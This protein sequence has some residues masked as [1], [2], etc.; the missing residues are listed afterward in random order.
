MYRSVTLVA[1][2]HGGL[3]RGVARAGVEESGLRRTV[4]GTPPTNPNVSP[5][6]NEQAVAKKNTAANGF[7]GIVAS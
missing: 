4:N 1:S 3:P 7:I 5:W 2:I 6:A